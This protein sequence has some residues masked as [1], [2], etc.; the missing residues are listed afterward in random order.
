[1][2]SVGSVSGRA[3]SGRELPGLLAG[4][5]AGFGA[6]LL[7][8]EF[9]GFFL[10]D[11]AVDGGEEDFDDRLERGAAGLFRDF[12]LLLRADLA[13]DA[14]SP[15]G[16]TRRRSDDRAPLRLLIGRASHLGWRGLLYDLPKFQGRTRHPQVLLEKAST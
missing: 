3:F 8:G 10:N 16:K 13:L 14:I 2:W 12:L 5:G 1:M 6:F 11:I 15:A 4:G 7:A 9:E